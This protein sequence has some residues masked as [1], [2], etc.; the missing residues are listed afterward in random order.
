MRLGAGGA[1]VIYIRGV[2]E[3]ELTRPRRANTGVNHPPSPGLNQS[4]LARRESIAYK[5]T[6][7]YSSYTSSYYRADQ[8]LPIDCSFSFFH[9]AR[10][11]CSSTPGQL[12]KMPTITVDRKE[13]FTRLGK[14]YCKH[15]DPRIAWT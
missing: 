7:H 4:H 15:L 8:D 12:V 14:E 6:L 11:A 3:A 10:S 13:F 1:A 9:F 5:G 2:P